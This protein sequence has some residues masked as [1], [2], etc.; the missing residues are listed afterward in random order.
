[1]HG[2]GL[3]VFTSDFVVP[4]ELLIFQQNAAAIGRDL[5]SNQHILHMGHRS[6]NADD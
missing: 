2:D 5:V 6:S 3:M 1:M 4:M